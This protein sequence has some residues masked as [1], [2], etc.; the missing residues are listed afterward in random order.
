MSVIW[1]LQV[2]CLESVSAV[3]YFNSGCNFSDVMILNT[4]IF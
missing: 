4:L 2:V 3:N 1:G